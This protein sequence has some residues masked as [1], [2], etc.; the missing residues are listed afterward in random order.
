MGMNKAL[1][2]EF[3]ASVDGEFAYRFSASFYPLFVNEIS[4]RQS[5]AAH[6]IEFSSVATN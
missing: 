2:H 3:A 4:S 5:A 1:W 6:D